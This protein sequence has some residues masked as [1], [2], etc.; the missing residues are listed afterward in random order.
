LILHGDPRPIRVGI[1]G[2]SR[3][4]WASVSHVP[5][6]ASLPGFELTAVSTTNAN[7]AREAA[8]A[9]GAKEWYDDAGSLASSENVDLVVVAVRTPFHRT[10]VL[11]A[12]DGGK[13]VYCEWPLGLDLDE[14]TELAEA[15]RSA[16]T[17]T[18][19][20]TQGRFAPAVQYLRDLI[21]DGYLGEVLSTTIVGSGVQWG[22][23]TLARNSYTLDHRNGSNMTT[24]PF[25][26]ALDAV[27]HVLGELTEVSATAAIRLPRVRAVDGDQTYEK[28]TPDQLVIAGSLE[29]GA[30][31]SAHYRGG[32]SRG[33]KLL[34][35]INGTHGDLQLTGDHQ[36]Q[37]SELTLSG[38]H[39]DDEGLASLE[40][41]AR[42][43]RA[44]SSLS[45][46]AANVAESYVRVE[47]DLRTG[48]RT[49]PSFDDAVTRHRMVH[50]VLEAARSGQKQSLGQT[51]M[52]AAPLNK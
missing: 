8:E 51:P 45:N 16:G 11:K 48:S 32:L 47:E 27:T 25:G 22:D 12:V 21:A 28:T 41:P 5:A 40:V 43:R 7:S 18:A 17:Y 23:V 2:G 50:A 49:A 13:S 6:L 52:H 26:H 20:G 24:I 29:S 3:D 9:F 19:I 30:V 36:L 4:G 37:V 35:E 44:H 39:G 15:A 33:T 14:A 31:L 1:I 34:W 38:A 42:Y 46:R 10:S